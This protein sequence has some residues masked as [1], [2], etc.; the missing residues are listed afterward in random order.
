MRVVWNVI[1]QLLISKQDTMKLINVR[2]LIVVVALLLV[3]LGL[4]ILISKKNRLYVKQKE[5]QLRADS[6]SEVA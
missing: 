3:A 6:K 5:Q 2:V 1:S 4:S